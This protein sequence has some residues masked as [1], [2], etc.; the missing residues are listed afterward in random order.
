VSTTDSEQWYWCTKDD[1]AERGPGCP[2]Q[3]RMGPYASREEA[4]N[5]QQKVEGRNDRWEDDDER[6]EGR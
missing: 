3:F 6:W 1:R 4:L 5:W 2:A